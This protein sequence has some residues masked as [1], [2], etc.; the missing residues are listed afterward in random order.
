M[1]KH[2]CSSLGLALLLLAWGGANNEAVAQLQLQ[3]VETV[4]VATAADNYIPAG[5]TVYNEVSDV[6]VGGS[7]QGSGP[8]VFSFNN[9]E[10]V[11]KALY[12]RT[13]STSMTYAVYG[14]QDGYLLSLPAGYVEI[15]VPAFLWGEESGKLEVDVLKYDAFK[16]LAD[17][18][19]VAS[20]TQSLTVTTKS[21]EGNAQDAPLTETDVVSLSFM[22]EEK[23]NYVVKIS[24]T[25]QYNNF[26]ITGFTVKNDPL[27]VFVEDFANVE[28]NYTPAAGSGWTIYAASTTAKDKGIDCATT[29]VRGTRVFKLASTVLKSAMYHEAYGIDA[30]RYEIYGEAADGEPSLTLEA[31]KY[32][33]SLDA[34]IWS[35]TP[36]IR[37]YLLDAE[38]SEI[39]SLTKSLTATSGSKTADFT[40]ETVT[41]TAEVE[42]AGNYM[43][44]VTS[45]GE[46]LY[47]NIAIRKDLTTALAETFSGLN[48]AVPSTGWIVYNNGAAREQGASVGSGAR[49]F[50]ISGFEAI[51]NVAYM[52]W[53]GSCYLTYGEENSGKSLT[54]VAG[55][56]YRITYY[57]A[58]WDGNTAYTRSMKCEI[59]GND[60]QGTIFSR[61]DVLYGKCNGDVNNGAKFL[62]T[63]DFI[64]ATFT[65]EKSGN[66]TLKFTSTNTVLGN[67][68]ILD[69]T[70]ANTVYETTLDKFGYTS[71]CL[72]K[73]VDVPE[74]VTAYIGKLNDAQTA[75]TLT[76]IEGA[77]PAETG[78]ILVGE[79]DAALTLTPAKAAVADVTGN[80]LKGTVTGIKAPKDQA[81]YVL[82]YKPD[83]EAA[84]FYY[85]S[86]IANTEVESG[87]T[88][89]AI[90][91]NKAYLAIE[92]ASA[93]P[94]I[95]IQFGDEPGNV[96]AIEQI[97]SEASAARVIYDLSGRRLTELSK[98]GLYIVNGRKMLMR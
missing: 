74:G 31:G 76:A 22:N 16:D 89:R 3:E 27:A 65:P 25:S 44:K 39:A 81:V 69:N 13:Y 14:D 49:A 80:V 83:D 63:P 92:T 85:S 17:L 82:G 59:I 64:Q 68:S 46:M 66:Y 87:E 72:S 30:T 11:N 51:S 33:I 67:I 98:P 38:G 29:G 47:G 12:L 4:D 57:A 73:A 35:G 45:S 10:V 77:I 40:P 24:T 97:E 8:R 53:Q 60:N 2:L 26:A 86:T 54:L 5:W 58:N 32:Q 34:A 90:P 21:Y 23:G 78:V 15:Q 55:K 75:V 1:K 9:S 62:M 84:R 43:L 56:E 96:T 36:D 37:I 41:L 95:R 71:L 79:P 61:E 18:T 7:S 91:A 19:V 93:A 28:D 94:S 50:A 48:G 52:G 42:S 6:R 70:E 20:T 88:V